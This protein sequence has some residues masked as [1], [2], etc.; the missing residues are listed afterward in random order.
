VPRKPPNRKRYPTTKPYVSFPL[1]PR[2]D[3]RF[4]KMIR[5][6]PLYF[7]QH[8]DW[9]AALD[10]YHAQAPAA[11]AGRELPSAPKANVTVRQLANR[12][13]RD[14]EADVRHGTLKLKSWDDYRATLEKFVRFVGPQTPAKELGPDHFARFATHVRKSLGSYAFNRTRA[15]I[16]AWLSHA[17]G[18]EWVKPPI[19]I[20][21]GFKP[22]SA[23]KMRGDR[24]ARLFTPEQVRTLLKHAG[25]QMRAMILLGINGGFG[26]TDCAQLTR[27]K[28]DLEGKVIRYRRAKTNIQRTV[29]LWPETV[30]SLRKVL[31]LR[32]NDPLVFRTKSGRPW[33]RQKLSR[34]GRGI[35]I[36]AVA[37]RFGKLMDAAKIEM[38]GVGFYALRHTFA[39]YANE[40]RDADARRHIMGRKL[41]ELDDVYIEHLFLP[42]LKVLT[43]HVRSR[44]L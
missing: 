43:D 15:L 5:G 12:Y 24:K 29:P 28:I 23:G 27:D 41:P 14:R 11:T 32:P 9:Q 44:V 42:R 17:A 34:T 4:T 13:L 19:N 38:P 40:V 39:T 6:V 37:G 10:E 2:S 30:K 18:A 22:V 7:G 33:V 21:V 3:G 20:G 16:R 26:P 8:G 25:P 36:D 1:T 31:A 35:V